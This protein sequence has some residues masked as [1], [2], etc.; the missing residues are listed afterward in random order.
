MAYKA[1]PDLELLRKLLDYD[2]E[3]GLLF[4]RARP[5]EMFPNKSKAKRWNTRYAG[6]RA[7][8]TKA[9]QK[10][11]FA[12][13]ILSKNYPVHRILWALHTGKDPQN[14]IDHINGNP[15]DNRLCNL[16]EVNQVENSKNQKIP[17]NNTSGYIGVSFRKAN[18]EWVAYISVQ[19]RIHLGGFR[20]KEAAIAARKDAERRYGFHPNHGRGSST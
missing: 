6:K 17:K 18:N 9:Y 11:Y 16:R 7:G 5:V 2:P 10:G 3:T 20:T 15:G 12:V 4:W 1:L 8:N 13:C 19:K 14:Q